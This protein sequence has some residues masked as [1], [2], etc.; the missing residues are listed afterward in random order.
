MF[1]DPPIHFKP[2]LAPEIMS[3]SQVIRAGHASCSGLS[4]F[5]ASACRAVGVPA[6]VAGAA[7]TRT[8]AHGGGRPL[9]KEPPGQGAAALP[10][11][12]PQE[13]VP[14]LQRAHS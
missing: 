9:G 3:P 14:C 4:I 5:L 1:A 10:C 2:D 13:R 8:G 7:G 11:C 6:R 12:S